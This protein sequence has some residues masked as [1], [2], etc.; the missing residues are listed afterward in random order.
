MLELA[1]SSQKMPASFNNAKQDYS[2]VDIEMIEAR[3]E[4]LHD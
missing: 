2:G 4:E 1:E 3:D